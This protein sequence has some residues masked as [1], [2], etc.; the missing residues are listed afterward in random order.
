[1]SR[2]ISI[3]FRYILIFRSFSVHLYRYIPYFF[4]IYISLCTFSD[5][6]VNIFLYF[7]NMHSLSCIHACIHYVSIF[8][9]FC[10]SNSSKSKDYQFFVPG[11]FNNDFWGDWRLIFGRYW[12]SA[13][14]LPTFHSFWKP[15]RMMMPTIGMLR[16]H[17]NNRLPW[18][19]AGHQCSIYRGCRQGGCILRSFF[20]SFKNGKPKTIGFSTWWETGWEARAQVCARYFQS[21]GHCV[22]FSVVTG[23]VVPLSRVVRP[24]FAGFLAQED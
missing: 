20:A 5:M 11:A 8:I 6:F 14:C 21:P 9:N 15:W 16:A 23:F 2:G 17:I 10:M 18:A 22:P 4:D 19:P 3:Y 13:T 24:K 7:I 12:F 1:M